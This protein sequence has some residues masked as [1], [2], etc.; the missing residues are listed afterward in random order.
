M[1]VVV[2]VTGGVVMVLGLRV[3]VRAVEGTVQGSGQGTE[4]SRRR[5]EVRRVTGVMQG[6]EWKSGK[7]G[8]LGSGVGNFLRPRTV[9]LVHPPSILPKC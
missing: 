4:P 6:E 8:G 5:S 9:G 7:W 2:V 3:G 1:A